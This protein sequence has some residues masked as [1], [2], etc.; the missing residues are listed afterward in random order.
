[1]SLIESAF[2]GLVL[3]IFR[4]F[5][6]VNIIYFHLLQWYINVIPTHNVNFTYHFTKSFFFHVED[7]S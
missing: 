4:T 7:I 5:G 6:D 3:D 1:M 2:S